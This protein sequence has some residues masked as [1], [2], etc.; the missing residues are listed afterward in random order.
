MALVATAMTTPEEAV[1]DG[2]LDE[3]AITFDGFDAAIIGYGGQ[4]TGKRL[5]AYDRARM[6]DIL[7]ADGPMTWEEAEEYLSFNVECLW[8]GEGTPII[9]ERTE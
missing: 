7:M 6:I 9:I 2:L 1:A 8:A 5:V 4:Y 3:D